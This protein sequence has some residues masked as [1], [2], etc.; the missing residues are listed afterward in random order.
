MISIDPERDDP[1][2]LVQFVHSFNKNF[3]GA[4]GDNAT[5]EKTDQ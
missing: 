4:T 5:I 3:V 1:K 2:R